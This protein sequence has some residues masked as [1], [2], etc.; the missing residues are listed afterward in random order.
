MRNLRNNVIELI[1]CAQRTATVTPS[2]GVDVRK[3]AGPMNI[4]L[5]SSAATAGTAPTLDCKL[6]H[7]DVA[8]SGFAD[9]S[10]ASFA[11]VTTSDVT[12]MITV[13]DVGALKP[14]FR[15]VCTVGGTSTPTFQFGVSAV[16]KLQSGTN[17]TQVA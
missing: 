3:Y 11:Q 6:Q 2:T 9:V 1:P 14:F 17:S 7:S 13:N 5:Q 12:E 10:G 8:G 16:A 15:V 4:I